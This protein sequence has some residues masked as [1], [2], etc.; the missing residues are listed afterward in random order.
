[1]S[2]L[3]FR[4]IVILLLLLPACNGVSDNDKSVAKKDT[5]RFSNII[6]VKQWGD[7]TRLEIEKRGDTLIKHY[8]DLKGTKGDN[9]DDSYNVVCTYENRNIDSTVIIDNKKVKIKTILTE[10][11]QTEFSKGKNFFF[12]SQS[13]DTLFDRH[14]LEYIK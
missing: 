8:I 3:L 1:M 7:T 14:W 4:N 5:N 12:I 6:Q 2:T 11:Y 10:N 13:G 9:F